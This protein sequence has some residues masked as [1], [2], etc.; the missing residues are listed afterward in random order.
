MG[1]GQNDFGLDPSQW[2]EFRLLL[3]IIGVALRDGYN[4]RYVI[5]RKLKRSW[6]E[7]YSTV[8]LPQLEAVAERMKLV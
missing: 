3:K 5:L 6:A 2:L 1:T 8:A 7:F 4:H